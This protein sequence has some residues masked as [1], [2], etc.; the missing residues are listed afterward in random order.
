[1]QPA[2]AGS[3]RPASSVLRRS[4]RRCPRHCRCRCPPRWGVCSLRRSWSRSACGRDVH[5]RAYCAMARAVR[6]GKRSTDE[7]RSTR[8]GRIR[9]SQR[10]AREVRWRSQWTPE[11][12]F[13]RLR[14]ARAPSE[15]W[16]KPI[17]AIDSPNALAQ[18]VV[19][20][21]SPPRLPLP[22]HSPVEARRLGRARD[23]CRCLPSRPGR[24]RSSAAISSLR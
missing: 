13:R 18:P 11:A 3:P 21:T 6:E 23:A 2:S 22:V 7:L 9:N 4:R 20:R 15:K 24:P 16:R 10:R 8:S 17:D 12:S 1:M 19:T 14:L 5:W